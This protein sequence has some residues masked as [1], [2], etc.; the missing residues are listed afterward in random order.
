MTQNA[1]PFQE[2]GDPTASSIVFL[3]G[4]GVAGWM[5]KKQVEH[6]ADFHCIVPDFP[7]H[8]ENATERMVSTRDCAS[9][10]AELIERYA[11]AGKAHMVGHSMGAKIATDL[12]SFRPELVD[13]A[14][15]ASDLCRS[16]SLV[17]MLGNRS[18]LQLALWMMKSRSLRRLQAKELAFPDPTYIDAFEQET[19]QL[20]VDTLVTIL[21]EMYGQPI[22]PA[23]L[24]HAQLPVL[25]LAGQKEPRPIRLTV[26]DLVQAL[27]QAKGALIRNAKHN[28]PWA[29]WELFNQL[30][31]DWIT[32][33]SLLRDERVI[34][35][36]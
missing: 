3:H 25:V 15:I 1:L 7:G 19:Q 2:T 9:R 16:A 36:D 5:W 34:P 4:G 21:R 23:K 31:R 30:V 29:H 12:L 22:L 6:F 17:A 27:P 33:Q 10:V 28:F 26:S 35:V 24:S 11:H 18:L 14:V 8:G 32:T 20:S 13:H